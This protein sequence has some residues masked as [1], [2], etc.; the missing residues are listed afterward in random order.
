MEYFDNVIQN[1]LNL[2]L[3]KPTEKQKIR[4]TQIFNGNR[5]CV[6]R[7]PENLATI[8]D[9]IPVEDPV[10]RKVFN[11]PINYYG[12]LWNCGRCNS[13]HS[14]KC[15][16]LQEFYA[17]KEERERMEKE[18][19]IKTKLISDSTLR[20]A[21]QLGL[22]A[23]VMTMSG[24]G[25][26]QIVQAA[27][28]DPD[29]KDKSKIVLLGGINDVKNKKYQDDAEFAEN[30]GSTITKV[31]ELATSEPEKSIT[32]VNSHPKR[33]LSEVNPAERIELQ[34]RERYLHEKLGDVVNSMPT[35]DVP[36]KNVEIV[37][38]HYEVD[39][40]W[41]PT[42]EG[43]KEILRT[44][45]DFIESDQKLIWNENFTHH[46]YSNFRCTEKKLKKP[47]SYD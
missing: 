21:D 17:A 7:K 41:H 39:E 27:M 5:Y 26:G 14:G 19:E 46:Y 33:D 1:V 45:N 32:L 36:I 37:D 15:P 42:I 8:P 16:L 20:H 3:E 11:I 38:I 35:L 22:T 23:D 34:T 44:L 6:V 4:G 18:K 29:V 28:D 40:T 25:L 47:K 43:T 13:Q 30:I 24:G 2:T 12:K 9:F 10:T 31:M